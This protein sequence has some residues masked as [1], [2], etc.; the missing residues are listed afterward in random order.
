M[1][2]SPPG[3]HA[4]PSGATCGAAAELVFVGRESPRY[5]DPAP[6]RVATP[7]DFRL[8]ALH[9]VTTIKRVASRLMGST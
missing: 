6:G 2:N 5:R 1:E 8:A 7:V 9:P 4:M 3:I